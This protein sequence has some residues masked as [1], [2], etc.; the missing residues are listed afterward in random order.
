M[1]RPP[2]NAVNLEFI[3]EVAAV[4]R[5]PIWQDWWNLSDRSKIISHNPSAKVL[6]TLDILQ[7]EC[8]LQTS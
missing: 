2:V 3:E 5:Q 4:K 7:T 1:D 6:K 8:E